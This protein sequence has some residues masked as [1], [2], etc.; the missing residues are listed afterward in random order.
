MAD[1]YIT[2]TDAQTK[3][4]M[5]YV[6]PFIS[7]NSAIS[8]HRSRLEKIDRLVERSIRSTK[9]TAGRDS[10]SLPKEP[11]EE[12]V[13]IPVVAPQLSTVSA[14]LAKIFL[15]TDPPLRMFSAP[16]ASPIATQYNILYGQYSR[17]FQWRR[18]LLLC[19]ND[20]VR[21][22]FC[23]AEIKWNTRAVQKVHNE[24]GQEG[25]AGTAQAF[26]EGEK[27]EHLNPYNVIWDGS[28]PL[29]E[30]PLRGAYAGYIEQKT[31]IALFQFFRDEGIALSAAQR[32]ELSKVSNTQR[33]GFYVPDIN[34]VESGERGT[35]SFDKM[36]EGGKGEERKTSIH[37]YDVYT[38]YVRLFPSDFNIAS[39]NPDDINILKLIII[40]GSFLVAIRLLDNAHQLLP[41]T[42]G[43]ISETAIGLNSYTLAEELSPIQNTAT[44]L[45]NADIASLRRLI[46][47]RAIYDPN[48]VSEKDVNS[49]EPT[50]KIKL[51]RSLSQGVDL[52]SAYYAIPYED[53]GV[54][55]RITQANALLGFA[56]PISGT[57]QAME[58]Q[59][60]RGNK[61]AQE[62]NTIMASAGDRILSSAVFIDDQ[63]FSKI[64][65]I[66]LSDTLQYQNDISIYH[67]E[68]GQFVDVDMSQ[69]REAPLDF[70]IAANLVPPEELGS[71]EMFSSLLQVFMAR[72][73]LN[74]E[75]KVVD[76]LC[77]LAETRGVKYLTRFIRSDE[78]KQALLQQQIASLQLMNTRSAQQGEQQE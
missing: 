68:S 21:Y 35:L 69:L 23:A 41:I 49:R 12:N 40:N 67:K 22:N 63:F 13:T 19:I 47:D 2:P 38:I 16:E 60:I 30:V 1:S 39:D 57:N 71:M 76:A 10:P 52:R 20:A 25:N 15:R 9:K 62:F 18:N 28:T 3:D 7:A 75:F 51:K 70:E 36:W 32:K 42:F 53:R 17:T 64:R 26:E 78:E 61:S 74:M 8:D 48:M 50:A 45:Y 44:K 14:Q 24:I 6:E 4:I 77:Y 59:F 11:E 58:G 55:S 27:I 65:T 29:N 37:L 66:L 33:M 54:G 73:D 34:P 43:Q 46:S 31:K 56:S 72:E 5:S